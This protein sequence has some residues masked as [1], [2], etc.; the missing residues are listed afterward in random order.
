[1]TFLKKVQNAKD[2][3]EE[4]LGRYPKSGVALSFGKDSMALVHL[5]RE[6]KPDVLVFAV[7]SDTEFPET[8]A[9]R[10][11]TV[12][13]WGLNYKE[14]VFENDPSRGA[15]DC[16]RTV[17]VEKFKEAVRDLDAWFSG[18]R[19]DEGF[20]R[21]DFQYVEEKDGLVKINPILDFSE[22]DIWRYTAVNAIPVSSL[23]GRG[24]RSLSC[25]KCSSM[26]Q[27]ENE[28]E[29]A[30]RWQGTKFEGGECGIHT[31]SLRNSKKE[32]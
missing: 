2:I 22:R 12:K 25:S 8:L 11:K 29:R 30:G 19:K 9:L 10:D 1:M 28:T 26:E 32:E 7:L 24:Y 21:N 14:Y 4:Y 27:D 16:C 3:I 5:M 18:I 13:D 31:Q 20:T 17:K 6:V 23:Y 15:E